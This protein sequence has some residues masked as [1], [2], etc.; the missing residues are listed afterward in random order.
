MDEP[1]KRAL[2]RLRQAE[3][4]NA[5]I[6][7]VTDGAAGPQNALQRCQLLLTVRDRAAPFPMHPRGVRCPAPTCAPATGLMGRCPVLGSGGVLRAR[8]VW[9]IAAPGR[10]PQTLLSPE[11]GS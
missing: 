10:V 5:D 7:M 8:L 9:R 6:L 11:P 3:W 1:F 2:E 4:A